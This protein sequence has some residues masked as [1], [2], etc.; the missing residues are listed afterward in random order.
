MTSLRKNLWMIDYDYVSLFHLFA[1]LQMSDLVE[2]MMSGPETSIELTS[3]ESS[4]E[5]RFRHPQSCTDAQLV[6]L[7][8]ERE[9]VIHVC[10][11]ADA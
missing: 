2:A 5:S 10:A 3:T 8:I 11:V 6:A 7:D 1:K 9:I 4:L